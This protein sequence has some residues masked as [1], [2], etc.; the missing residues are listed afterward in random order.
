MTRRLLVALDGSAYAR[1]VLPLAEALARSSGRTLR[2]VQVV[3]GLD[4]RPFG[5]A[6]VAMAA[7]RVQHARRRQAELELH[8]LS[9]YLTNQ[10][11]SVEVAV[12]GGE[13]G[14]VLSGLALP[15]AADA[16]LISTHG[17]GGFADLL[18]GSVSGQVLR[19]SRIPVLLVAPWA[20][21]SWPVQN[22]PRIL[23]ALDG[24]PLAERALAAAIDLVRPEQP[25]LF[26]LSVAASDS[27]RQTQTAYLACLQ[28][29]ATTLAECGR[30][31]ET[32]AR[33]AT[34]QDVDLIAMGTHGH[35]GALRATLGS[36]AADTLRIA[37]VPLLLVPAAVPVAT[38]ERGTGFEPATYYLEGSRSRPG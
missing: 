5:S 13:P 12:P 20:Q 22:R 18:Y 35:G 34:E 27:Q 11:L 23:V 29:G 24:S 25:E 9:Q 38:R 21:V 4:V 1:R 37:D 3:P 28:P 14:R 16:V 7:R 26:L 33:L 19:G 2:L 8:E 36:V 30:P 17:D 32:I 10:G 31:A 6:E 15:E